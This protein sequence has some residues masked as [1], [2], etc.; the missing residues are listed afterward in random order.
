MY[1]LL[2]SYSKVG[3]TVEPGNSNSEGKPKTVRVSGGLSYRGRLNIQIA[4]LIIDSLLIF[5]HFSIQYTANYTYLVKNCN[6]IMHSYDNAV[7]SVT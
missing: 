4:M 6:R 5:Q 7:L 2:Y 1:Y 3:N